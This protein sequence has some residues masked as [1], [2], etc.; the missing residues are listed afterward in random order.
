MKFEYTARGKL[1]I[2]NPEITL[3]KNRGI[4]N[5]QQF[6][7]P[8]E[9][10]LEPVELLDNIEEAADI[11]LWHMENK[12]NVMVLQD[13]DCDGITSAALIM[14][15][16][17]DN[18][19]DITVV[20]IIHD[21]K[22]HGLDPVSMEKILTSH[23]DLLIIPD[24][25]SN[26]LRQLKTL[27]ENSIDVIVLD[28]HDES[29]QSK[30]LKSLYKLK[31]LN[32]YAWI[33]NNQM[34]D[35]VQDKSMTGVGIT[36]KFCTLLDSRLN[37]NTSEKYLDLVVVGMVADSCDLTQLQTRHLVL[38]GIK[39]IQDG[40]NHNK[41]ITELVTSQSFSLKGKL[42]I[43]GI[44]FTIAPLINSLIR[45]G[46]Q[47]D[48]QYLLKAFLNSEEKVTYKIRGKGETEISVQEYARRLCESYKRKQ[49]KMASDYLE[50]VKQQVSDYNLDTLPVICCKAENN[51][52]KTFTGLIANKLTSTYN[53]PC[54]L[55]REND[56]GELTGS[57]RGFDK[58]QIKD[59]KD[60]CLKSSFFSLAEGHPNSCGVRISESKIGEFYD[61][62]S[63]LPY[64]NTLS[65][66]VDAVLTENTLTENLIRQ[67]YKLR[68]IWGTN[69]PEPL[70]A[71]EKINVS[72]T[73]ISL[74]GEN[75][76]T[77]KFTF[78]NID[79]IKFSSS[80]TEYKDIIN[81]GDNIT[82]TIIGRLSVNDYNGKTTPQVIVENWSYEKSTQAV[83]KFR[84]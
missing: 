14:N 61:Y 6:I 75:K 49:Q 48:K 3:L 28:H 30:K 24:A 82:F 17:H 72:K 33:V 35:R 37:K 36:H 22:E 52:E 16:T 56:N 81:T 43:V 45:L 18:F 13:C 60:F 74:L 83:K 9:S 47:E 12:S 54:I 10:S 57:A 23:P 42:T 38:K 53:R 80:E 51:F 63:S 58:S 29:R 65:Y 7:S 84:F 44:S 66:T 76:T 79:I 34:S 26:D 31:N 69:V 73:D 64:D 15:Y 2:G 62:L 32:A 39:Q 20:P 68:D 5:P 55:L 78:H 8:P 25:G 4:E 59:I 77:I 11:F 46:T 19:P 41:F 71:I 70:F 21:N 27:R 50:V 40:T 67:I 1:G